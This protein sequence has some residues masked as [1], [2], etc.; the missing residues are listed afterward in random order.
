MGKK[1]KHK[2]LSKTLRKVRAIE[3]LMLGEPVPVPVTRFCWYVP[4]SLEELCKLDSYKLHCIA[5]DLQVYDP[6]SNIRHAKHREIAEAVHAVLQ[7]VGLREAPGTVEGLLALGTFRL[8]RLVGCFLALGS[9]STADF[10]VSGRKLDLTDEEVAQRV[11]SNLKDFDRTHGLRFIDRPPRLA[12]E[13]LVPPVEEPPPTPS[14]KTLRLF[15]RRL[16][17][18]RTYGPGNSRYMHAGNNKALT[19]RYKKIGCKPGLFK[20]HKGSRDAELRCGCAVHVSIS[21]TD[22]VWLMHTKRPCSVH[23]KEP[24]RGPLHVSLLKK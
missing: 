20:G 3:A 21:R 8:R 6:P 2:R 5:Y 11:L 17:Y 24:L 19:G 16:M 10:L 9:T 7:F 14:A 23:V 4:A 15:E 22:F 18:V 1:K 13:D 12:P